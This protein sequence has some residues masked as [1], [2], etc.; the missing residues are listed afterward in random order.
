MDERVCVKRVFKVLSV[1]FA[2]VFCGCKDMGEHIDKNI[3]VIDS[4]VASNPHI[5]LDS[6]NRITST[7]V[8]S[9]DAQKAYIYLL[10]VMALN[11]LGYKVQSDSLINFSYCFYKE[12]YDNRLKNSSRTLFNYARACLYKAIVKYELNPKDSLVYHLLKDAQHVFEEEGGNSYCLA[13]T[14]SII[15]HLNSYTVSDAAARYY[16]LALNQFYAISDSADALKLKLDIMASN[17]VTDKNSAYVDSLL[18][19]II[20]YKLPDDGTRYRYYNFCAAYYSIKGNN[21]RAF[22]YSK[23]K[24][25]AKPYVYKGMGLAR[26]N[27]TVSKY[28]SQMMQPDSALFY[29]QKAVIAAFESEPESEKSHLYFRNL[30]DAWLKAGDYR[31]ATASYRKAVTLSMNSTPLFHANRIAEIEKNYNND[32]VKSNM[33]LIR[34]EANTGIFIILSIV[35]VLLL[36]VVVLLY[37]NKSNKEEKKYMEL[38]HA[39]LEN[40]LRQSKAMIEVVS[41]SFGVLPDFIEKVNELSSRAF[42]SDSVLFDSFQREIASVKAQ[43]RKRLLDLVNNKSF[44]KT[45]PILEHLPM[46]SNQEKM[47]TLLIDQ[48]Y[49]TKYIAGLLNITQ[50]SVR[51]S[52][53]KIK[54]KIADSDIPENVKEYILPQL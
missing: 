47:I 13:K 48:K 27:Y 10:N 49:N 9:N 1:V 17:L 22:L 25:S 2:F 5:A 42:S 19:T 15:G 51:A 20:E 28:F 50:S 21:D 38:R 3:F 23:L 12:R 41:V 32:L 54:R 7:G 34:A 4:L 31:L 40:D 18:P 35:L 11:R 37:K 44:I 52:K 6:V 45:Y 36:F 24:T 8:Y 30:G 26:Y 46:L 29:A 43:M 16:N 33:R 14:Y 53:I 39:A